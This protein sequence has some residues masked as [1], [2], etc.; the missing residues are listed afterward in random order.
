MSNTGRHPRLRSGLKYQLIGSQVL[1]QALHDSERR[2]RSS[3]TSSACGWGGAR[4]GRGRDSQNRVSC[5]LLLSPAP[6]YSRAQLPT[7]MTARPLA[8][9]R[10]P[11]NLHKMAI[12]SARL[13]PTT[14]SEVSFP[15]SGNETLSSR[16]GEATPGLRSS[17]CLAEPRLRVPL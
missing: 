13:A 4:A 14:S 2:A 7:K 5:S 9:H 11:A 15:L 6:S 10:S 16:W 12:Y 17:A 8:C 3:P 1:R